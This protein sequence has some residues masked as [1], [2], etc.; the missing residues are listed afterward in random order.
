MVTVVTFLWYDPDGRYNR[1]YTYGPDHVNRMRS[2]LSR[3]L[4]MPHEMVCVTDIPQG[5]HPDVRVVPLDRSLIGGPQARYPKLMAWHPDAALWF[6]PR[7]L[8][9]DLDTVIVRDIAPI[10]DRPEPVVL[11]RNSSWGKP[12]RTRY[13]TSIAL[14]D[15]GAR[16]DIWRAFSRG[17]HAARHDQELVSSV[18]GT[19]P[20]GSWGFNDDDGI[21][22]ARDMKAGAL[23]RGC[24]VVTFAGKQD[25]SER[26]TR[27]RFP[28]IAEHWR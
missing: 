10:V 1:L 3:H 15:A 8:L 16:P 2:M 19:D 4:N 24:R 25:P 18:V 13:N 23:P 9:L 20:G 21:Y 17:D 22:K 5:L 28:W 26:R 7:I 27:K 12:G 14:L 11:W 6:G